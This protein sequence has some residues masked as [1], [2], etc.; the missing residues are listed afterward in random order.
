MKIIKDSNEDYH[1]KKS[2][3]ASGLKTIFKKSVNHFLNQKPFSSKSMELGTAVHTIM[4]EG[5]E[6]FYKDYYLLP[7]LD[8]RYK[9]DK[10]QFK[11]HEKLAK[12]RSLLK[13]EEMKIIDG[14]MLNFKT[15]KVAQESCSGEIELS[16]YGEFKGVPVRVRP[17]VKGKD[18]IGDVKTCQ[19]NSPQSFKRDVFKFNYHLQACFYSDVLGYDPEKFRFIAV[20]TNYPYTI[21][22]YQMGELMI[23]RG[24]EAYN[25]ALEL[26]KLYL[27][28]GIV[29]AYITENQ[30]ENGTIIL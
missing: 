6:Q 7:K 24:R 14:I 25:K 26:W 13:E 5:Q 18:F 21:Q 22:V 20:E 3:S 10:E 19:D 2:I 4:L 30:T 1:S 16:H 12:G 28:T 29:S 15:D 17:D 27:D 23:E 9:A 11:Q 8:L